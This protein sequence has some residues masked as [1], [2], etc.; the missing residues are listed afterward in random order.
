[1]LGL[2]V[3]ALLAILAWVSWKMGALVFN[4]IKKKHDMVSSKIPVVMVQFLPIFPVPESVDAW[5]RY[6]GFYTQES[7]NDA[8]HKTHEDSKSPIVQYVCFGT[9]FTSVRT[10]DLIKDV[11]IRKRNLVMK[12][13]EYYEV[14]DYYGPN[15][16]SS[17]G[18]EWETIR[19]MLN[20]VF[21]LQQHLEMVAEASVRHTKTFLK[22]YSG[23]IEPTKVMS[24]LTLDVIGSVLFGYE[25]GALTEQDMF[26]S[27]KQ[28]SPNNATLSM[29]YIFDNLLVASIVHFF[30]GRSMNYIPISPFI[31]MSDVLKN[32]DLYLEYIYEMRKKESGS[33]DT[34][35]L[36]VSSDLE[37]N[38]IKANMFLLFFAG[39]D[40]TSRGLTWALMLLAKHQDIQEK[41]FQQVSTV[42][43]GRNPTFTDVKDLWYATNIFKECLR[44]YS[45]VQQILKKCTKE[46]TINDHV[47]MPDSMVLVNI[48]SLH[49]DETIWPKP[50]DF[51][52]ERY[53]SEIPSTT[54]IPF[55]EGNR[56]CL[57]RQVA[58]IEATLALSMIFQT[59]RVTIA[60]N[61]P[62]VDLFQS[63]TMLLV[64]PKHAMKV[65]L[66]PR[67][68]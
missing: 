25:V 21:T 64:E 32:F 37:K 30:F 12:P 63:K 59:Y 11:L 15:I 44:L 3:F 57:G 34:L 47:I 54:W 6:F 67:V 65:N 49:H 36:L 1:M 27:N 50:F 19:K 41:L 22:F 61:S 4:H 45:P 20:P 14:F 31:E 40:T 8:I 18:K 51:I 17:N 29:R 38:M 16:L 53:E 10:P 33:Y 58:L 68:K 55:S 35:S 13:V 60:E 24:R 23:E 56:D 39:F 62:D 52:P 43:Q 48:Y 5:L 66:I 9:V 2:F 26:V 46:F 42:L 7:I 28:N